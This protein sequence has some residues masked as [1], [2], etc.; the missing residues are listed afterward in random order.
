M[1]IEDI[2]KV[3][4]EIAAKYYIKK[5]ILFGSQ[6]DGTAT[7]KSDIDLIIEF[8]KQVSLITISGLKLELEEIFRKQVDIIHGP[9]TD[10]DFIEVTREVELYA[11]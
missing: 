4:E 1:K 10:K 6:A 11:A 3:I 7:P 5:V 2:K 8:S 9:L